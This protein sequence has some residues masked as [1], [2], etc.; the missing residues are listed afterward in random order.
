MRAARDP[1]QGPRCKAS[2]NEL[3]LFFL[4]H[5]LK[6]FSGYFTSGPFKVRLQINLRFFEAVNF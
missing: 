3:F 4:K 5:F 1:Q 2:Y 6:L